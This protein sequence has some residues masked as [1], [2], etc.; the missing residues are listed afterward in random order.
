[1]TAVERIQP[2]AGLGEVVAERIRALISAGE[3]RPGQLLPPERDLAVQFDVSRSI[4]RE[5][6]KLLAAQNLV[7]RRQGRG[8][9]VASLAPEELIRPFRFAFDLTSPTYAHLHQARMI[10]EPAIAALAAEN[11]TEDDLL[12]LRDLLEEEDQLIRRVKATGA[13]PPANERVRIDSAIHERLARAANN[14]VIAHVMA[15][16]RTLTNES[17]MHTVQVPGIETVVHHDHDRLY[18]AI[19]SKDPSAAAD[20]MRLHLMNV[21]AHAKTHASLD[22]SADGTYS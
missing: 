11:A 9:H 22:S 19:K 12:I 10:L 6:L 18:Q 14:P 8:T 5:G 20:A 1:M 4:V 7:V 16:I 15:M 21:R 2:Q 13:S 3:L 17:R